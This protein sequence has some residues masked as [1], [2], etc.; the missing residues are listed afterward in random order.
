MNEGGTAVEQEIRKDAQR[1]SPKKQDFITRISADEL[2][3]IGSYSSLRFSPLCCLR[4]P[5]KSPRNDEW[6]ALYM[7]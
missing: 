3:V 6:V 2:K 5:C 1:R 7:D 4:V